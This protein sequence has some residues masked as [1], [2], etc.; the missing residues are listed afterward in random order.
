MA[1]AIT[2]ATEAKVEAAIPA[3]AGT[4]SPK[5]YWETEAKRAF[6][7][8]NKAQARL[9]DIEAAAEVARQKEVEEKGL[10]KAELE[11][12]KPE[13]ESLKKWKADADARLDADIA[14]FES[15]VSADHKAEYE[16]YIK[17]LPPEQR[18]EWLASKVPASEIT[19]AS[20]P[21][22]SRPGATGKTQ[23]N[24]S[25]MSFDDRIAAFKVNP[26]SL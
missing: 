1:D 14:S 19:P 12:V 17:A 24:V 9:K 15:K 4:N 26:K 11:K 13:Y 3:E 8:R 2:P 10:Y 25:G 6:E 21:S 7:D 20:S 23:G 16:K 22:A 18:R 5:G